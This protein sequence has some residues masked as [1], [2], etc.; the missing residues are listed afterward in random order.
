MPTVQPATRRAGNA[1]QVAHS[2]RPP[3]AKTPATVPS[4]GSC[5]YRAGLL[6]LL[7]NLDEA[8]ALGRGQRTRL[9][10]G[11]AVAAGGAPVLVMDLDLRG[12]PDDLAVQRVPHTVFQLD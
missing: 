5:C 8:P 3:D 10:Q 12:G 7:E 11:D 2:T 4:Q 9:H 6:G 1:S